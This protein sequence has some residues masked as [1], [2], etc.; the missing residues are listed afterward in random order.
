[1]SLPNLLYLGAAFPPGIK[2]LFPEL[3]AAGHTIETALIHSISRNYNIR[4]IGFAEVDVD[5]PRVD[6]AASPGL[7]N[8][9]NLLDRPPT[10]LN[11]L[12][13]VHRLRRAYAAWSREGWKPDVI[14]TCNFYPI[15]NTF[16]RRVARQTHRP[17]LVLYLADS[18]QLGI[19]MSTSKRFS[20][21]LKPMVWL[22]D[23]MAG[24]Y[25]AC[26]AVSADTEAW[27]RSRAKPWLWLPN[28]ID[29]ARVRDASSSPRRGP[30]IFGYFGS[31][32]EHA[33]LPRLLR[34]FTSSSREASL[35]VC[36]FGKA[37]VRLA[38]EYSGAANVSFHGPFD[39]EGCVDFGCGCDVLVNPRPIVPGNENNFSSKVFEY[40]LTGRSILSSQLS[41][42]ENVLGPDAFY[43]DASDFERSLSSSLTRIAEL[44]RNELSR[45]G[46][47]IQQRMASEFSWKAQGERLD[48]FLQSI[49]EN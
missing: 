6:R 25:D 24:L 27:F 21:R 14:L 26:V 17:L 7:D 2:P 11:R 38:E 45:R 48:R 49:L 28:G 1:M 39:P 20:Y 29:P 34:L 46:L 43:F 22:D 13:S 10:L 12:R 32:G 9:L 30:V 8:E 33:G 4:S 42:V 5:S 36:A 41:G 16:I 18:T 47:A 37:R 23:E 19:R 31:A 44:E 40:A 35:R 15:Y 3:K